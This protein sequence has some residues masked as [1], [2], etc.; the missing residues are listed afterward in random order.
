M[1]Q[2]KNS[3]EAVVTFKNHFEIHIF[4]P[5][6]EMFQTSR[7]VGQSFFFFFYKTVEMFLQSGKVENKTT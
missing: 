5:L 4:A 2:E 1:K 7:Q 3:A 6:K